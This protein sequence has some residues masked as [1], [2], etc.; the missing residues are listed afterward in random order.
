MLAVV[1]VTL[2]A[3]LLGIDHIHL[4]FAVAKTQCLLDI[5]R[6]ALA[7]LL[8]DHYPVDDGFDGMFFGFGKLYLFIE[9]HHHPV[10]HGAHVPFLA[11]I[12]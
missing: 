7:V 3:K 10:D 5:L 4:H 1:V 9:A 8:L 6:D 2:G 11:K 12:F